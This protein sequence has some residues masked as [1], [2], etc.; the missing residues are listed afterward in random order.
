VP[1]ALALLPDPL[2]LNTTISVDYVNDTCVSISAVVSTGQGVT[3]FTVEL[4][5]GP[6]SDDFNQI[7]VINLD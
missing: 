7:A 2:P 5:D 4:A 6:F 1:T 3:Q